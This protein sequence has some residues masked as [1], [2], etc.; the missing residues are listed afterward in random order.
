[1]NTEEFLSHYGMR[2]MKWGVRKRKLPTAKSSRKT[3]ADFR[4][5]DVLRKKHHSELT[6]KQLQEANN[7]LGLEQRFTQLT[8]GK[9]RAGKNH[10]AE[11]LGTAGLA[12][13]AYNLLNSPAGKA[14][15]SVG[16]KNVYK[17]M[18]LFK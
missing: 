12:I 18:Q 10:V 15:R 4:K 1:M 6:N 2:G 7:R 17:Q 3:S 14:M 13:S 16:K 8:P 5:V 9:V 11:I